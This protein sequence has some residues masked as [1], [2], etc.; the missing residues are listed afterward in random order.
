MSDEENVWSCIVF[1]NNDSAEEVS[2]QYRHSKPLIL[3]RLSSY[4]GKSK[5][6][7]HISGGAGDGEHAG[8]ADA[9]A[10]AIAHLMSY[11]PPPQ[12]AQI[13]KVA[14]H[15]K[16]N[17][18]MKTESEL[19]EIIRQHTGTTPALEA[20]LTEKNPT[21]LHIRNVK[22]SFDNWKVQRKA[23]FGAPKKKK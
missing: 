2:T 19:S 4:S 23:K 16:K 14:D 6:H 10:A 18:N 7:G 9:R 15:A 11:T 8:A 13:V 3:N 1:Y 5:Y 20:L 12:T 22:A 21:W 17:S